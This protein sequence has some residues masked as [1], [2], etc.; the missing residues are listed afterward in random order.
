MEL[1]VQ[2]RL[3]TTLVGGIRLEQ[4]QAREMSFEEAFKILVL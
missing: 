2:Y 4:S 3:P 1:L